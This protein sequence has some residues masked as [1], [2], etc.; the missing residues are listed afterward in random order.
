MI[1]ALE[2]EPVNIRKE[3]VYIIP[4]FEAP[5]LVDRAL[6]SSDGAFIEHMLR[7]ATDITIEGTGR[8][9]SGVVNP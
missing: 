2:N 7:H 5:V 8:T 4:N 1:L 6:V 9:I 3:S